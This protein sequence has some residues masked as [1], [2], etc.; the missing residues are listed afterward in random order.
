MLK[1]HA[2]VTV[3]N[4][5]NVMHLYFM[6][7]MSMKAPPEPSGPGYAFPLVTHVVT[8]ANRVTLFTEPHATS[9][10]KRKDCSRGG[11][12]GT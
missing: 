11:P 10:K 4:D 2:A 5:C 1:R 12:T 3:L 8:A 6:P 9:L 7:C